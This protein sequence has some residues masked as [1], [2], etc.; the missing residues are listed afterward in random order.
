M[1]GRPLAVRNEIDIRRAN[2]LPFINGNVINDQETTVPSDTAYGFD[3]KMLISCSNL[4]PK[5]AILLTRADSGAPVPCP[6]SFHSLK[7]R[8][9]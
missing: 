9:Q 6:Q 3:N 7:D 8:F 1:V 5:Q 2:A 4:A